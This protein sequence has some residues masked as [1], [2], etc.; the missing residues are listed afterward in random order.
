MGTSRINPTTTDMCQLDWTRTAKPVENT[1]NEDKHKIGEAFV[2]KTTIPT[3][4][5]NQRKQTYKFY[6]GIKINDAKTVL[7]PNTSFQPE[8]ELKPGDYLGQG[9]L[10]IEPKAQSP[11][12]TSHTKVYFVYQATPSKQEGL[13]PSITYY[14][15]DPRNV[16]HISAGTKV[17]LERFVHEQVEAPDKGIPIAMQN[18]QHGAQIDMPQGQQPATNTFYTKL[19]QQLGFC[20]K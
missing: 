15:N 6:P 8:V 10:E 5:I 1:Y 13:P 19:M 4:A 14:Y 20:K 11:H 2:E 17:E 18:G 7:I 9:I 12:N 3:F 16:N